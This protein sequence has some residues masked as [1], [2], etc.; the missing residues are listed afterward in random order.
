[1]GYEMGLDTA[2]GEV[3]QVKSRRTR[4]K[5]EISDADEVSVSDALLVLI[6]SIERTPKQT[7]GYLAVS[8]FR[9]SVSKPYSR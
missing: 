2:V 1:V 9:S 6:Q 8:A 7:R 3:H 4:G 5:G